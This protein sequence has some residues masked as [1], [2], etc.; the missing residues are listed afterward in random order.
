MSEHDLK[1]QFETDAV[2]NLAGFHLE[3]ECSNGSIDDDSK[4]IVYG[5]DIIDGIFVDNE[6][7][8]SVGGSPYNIDLGYNEFVTS[9]TFGYHTHR[10]GMITQFVGE[11]LSRCRLQPVAL[12]VLKLVSFVESKRAIIPFKVGGG[13]NQNTEV[14]YVTFSLKLVKILMVQLGPGILN[15]DLQIL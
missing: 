11:K 7:F 14:I 13:P 10:F 9:I 8:G 1:I 12:L 4:I 2:V 6:M 3:V 15:V 5:G